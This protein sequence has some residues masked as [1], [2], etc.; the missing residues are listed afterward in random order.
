MKK[1]S[2]FDMIYMLIGIVL[3]ILA[4]L[5]Y[6]KLNSNIINMISAVICCIYSIFHMYYSLLKKKLFNGKE[7]YIFPGVFLIV[8]YVMILIMLIMT[9][10]IGDF[11]LD[12]YLWSLYIEVI[13]IPV[14][15]F[16][17]VYFS[18]DEYRYDSN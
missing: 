11:G 2:K 14:L 1:F 16:G 8:L 9:N 5:L 6:Y 10:P 3:G 13:S 4:I 12:Y 18:N 17:L 7:K 15:Y